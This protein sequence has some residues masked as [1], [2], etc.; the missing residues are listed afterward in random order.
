MTRYRWIS[1]F[2][3]LGL[4]LLLPL[5]ALREP[6]RMAAAQEQARGRQL[7][8]GVVVYTEY[9][10]QCHGP[11]GAGAGAMPSLARPA[12]AGADPEMLFRTIARAEHGTTMAAWHMEEGGVLN[13]YQIEALVTV[14]RHADWSQ[15]SAQAAAQGVAMPELRFPD[16]GLEYLMGE[17]EDDPHRCVA[18]HEEPEVHAEKFGVNC[19]RCHTTEAWAPAFLTRHLFLLDHGSEGELDCQV[20]HTENYY[21]HTCYECHDHTPGQMKTAHLA[22]GLTEIDACT[23]CHPTGQTGEADRLLELQEAARGVV[24]PA[25][26]G[27]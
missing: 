17:G 21:S 11:D 25:K 1:L 3:F 26:S 4:V 13:D 18:C 9:C 8:D 14:I 20:C 16:E 23:R 12:L 7:V 2:A 15:V 6:G 22:E 24:F 10:A 19:A 5:Y 27:Q